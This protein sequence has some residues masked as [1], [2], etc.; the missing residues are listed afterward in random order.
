MKQ[1]SIKIMIPGDPIP[2]AR[3]GQN[4]KSRFDTQAEQKKSVGLAVIAC[5][6]AY[7]CRMFLG[8]I[9]VEFK[10]WMPVPKYKRKQ[11]MDEFETG[12][13]VWHSMKP[14]MSN[15]I[16][17]YEDALNGILWKD[18]SAIVSICGEKFYSLQPA[19]VIKVWE[20]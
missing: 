18:D 14:D 6:S 2:W 1:E 17:F 4:K 12:L 10:F 20:L 7:P 5:M 19:T 13:K 9:K 16:K 8:P 3:P 11:I 15:L